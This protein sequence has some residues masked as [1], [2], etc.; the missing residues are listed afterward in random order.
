VID[1][2]ADV[3]EG[4]IAP[5]DERALLATVTSA[6][7]SCG[8]HAGTPAVVADTVA[9]ALAAGVALGAHPSYPDRRGF[10][11]RFV[12]MSDEALAASLSEQ[13]AIVAGLARQHGA[14]L[15]YVKPHGALYHR[16]ATDPATARLLASVVAAADVEVVLLAAGAP[17]SAAV[18]EAGLRVVGEA[19]ADRAYGPDG[20]LVPREQ[21]GGVLDDEETVVEQARS[22]AVS[23]RVRA[24]DGTVI[25]LDASS[26]C[27][28]GDTPG[29]LALA[30][31]VRRA[32]EAD[33][34][35]LAP[36]SS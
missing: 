34:I 22:I 35:T 18:E 7:V 11:R 8:A 6:S 21:E 10:G 31:G 25:A 14:R 9:A 20:T 3:G 1:L 13:L 30:R 15:R 19:F 27:L 2:N 33:G 4:V 24:V 12:E 5:A 36:F 23:G 32:L 17:T 28:H 29:A 16:V 26:L